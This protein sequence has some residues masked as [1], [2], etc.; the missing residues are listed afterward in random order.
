MHHMNE[1]RKSFVRTIFAVAFVLSFGGNGYSAEM[2]RL[3]LGYSTL[4]PAGTGLWMA[5]EIGAFEN[6]VSTP[7]SFSFRP[8]PSSSRP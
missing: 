5:K 6:M 8:V 7:I 2:Q 4:G 1:Q 3:T